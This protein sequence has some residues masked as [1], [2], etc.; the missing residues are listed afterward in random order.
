[1][2]A[3]GLGRREAGDADCAGI[4]ENGRKTSL[5]HLP[6]PGSKARASQKPAGKAAARR[7]LKRKAR[8]A[9]KAS[10]KEQGER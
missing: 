3:Y 1:M 4:K 6:G 2:K 9:G 8:V 7:H 10:I 5:G